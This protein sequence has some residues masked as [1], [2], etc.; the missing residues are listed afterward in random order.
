M[1]SLAKNNNHLSTIGEIGRIIK[2]L[3]DDKKTHLA[4]I[5]NQKPFEQSYDMYKPSL[6]FTE[7]ALNTQY[8]FTIDTFEDKVTYQKKKNSASPNYSMELK[9]GGQFNRDSAMDSFFTKNLQELKS[10]DIKLNM[11]G[12]G[13]ILKQ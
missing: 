13:S 1:P 5:L 7:E 6:P 11:S 4:K 2:K 3:P 9:R 10:H 12:V 8:K